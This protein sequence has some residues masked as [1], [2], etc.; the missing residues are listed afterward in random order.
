MIKLISS[1]SAREYNVLLYWYNCAYIQLFSVPSQL[2]GALHFRTLVICSYFFLFRLT[3][4]VISL[5][6]NSWYSIFL[7]GSLGFLAE[8][9]SAG[10]HAS[11]NE[12]CDQ[13]TDKMYCH[14]FFFLPYNS[15]QLHLN[16]VCVW[17]FC[18][19]ERLYLIRSWT[20]IIVFSDHLISKSKS[21]YTNVAHC[22]FTIFA[23]T[24]DGC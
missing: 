20:M 4:S 5:Y 9:L 13:S 10:R 19:F 24:F 8:N 6:R 17:V 15:H 18:L 22:Q 2:R 21:L 23:K 11:A 16:N 7:P 3:L 12:H 14:F 1:F